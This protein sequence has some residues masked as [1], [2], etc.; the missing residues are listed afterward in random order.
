[1]LIPYKFASYP[2]GRTDKK[3]DNNITRLLERAAAGLTRTEKDQVAEL[4]YG[5]FGAQS[6]TYKLG[7]W[8]WPMRSVLPRFLVNMRGHGW[9]EY[10][11]PDKTSLRR[12][13][14]GVLEIVQA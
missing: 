8:A 3:P 10:Y 2:D 12:V 9:Q 4:L 13:L 7:G 6:S 1:M 14:S 11:A 5:L